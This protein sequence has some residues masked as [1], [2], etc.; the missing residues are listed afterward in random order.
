[1]SKIPTAK[2]ARSQETLKRLRYLYQS[3]YFQNMMDKNLDVK[4][5]IR[6]R[7]AYKRRQSF[8]AEVCHRLTEG[9]ENHKATICFGDGGFSRSSSGHQVCI[10][11]Q[12]FVDF[13]CLEGWHVIVDLEFKASL[14]CSHC[15]WRLQGKY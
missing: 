4:K 1:M 10:S 13:L 12:P 5:H 15:R 9:L 3:P 6:R 2:T 14:I 11:M 7:E 8:I